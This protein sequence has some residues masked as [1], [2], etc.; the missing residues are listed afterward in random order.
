[1]SK[2]VK[3]TSAHIEWLKGGALADREVPGLS[4]VVA[5][6]ERKQRRFKRLVAGMKKTVELILGA[7][8]AF[9]IDEAREWAASFSGVAACGEDTRA[10]ERAEDAVMMAVAAAHAI[11]LNAIF[12]SDIG[13]R[14]GTKV[15]ADLTEDDWRLPASGS[16]FERTS[17]I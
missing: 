9:S 15:L 8:P 4:V 5:A 1:M 14:L 2:P 11:H 10:T 6:H 12:T 16:A 7:Y 13:P 17:A 3:L